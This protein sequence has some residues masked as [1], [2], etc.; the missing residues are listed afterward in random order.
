MRYFKA[1]AV[2]AVAAVGFHAA[3]AQAA[4]EHR[5]ICVF[6]IIG[7]NGDSFN[8]MRDYK[9][10]AL[11]WGVDITLKPYT[12]E[13]IAAEDLKAGQCDGAILTGL[14]IRQFNSY[15]GSME[16]IG[17]IPNYKQ[18]HTVMRVLMSNNPTINKH[19]KTEHYTIGGLYPMG[20]AYLFVKDKSIDTVDELSGKSIA[21]MDYLSLIHI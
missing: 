6:D 12:N 16:A 17:A 8:L 10:A 5:T 11:G 7:S 4:L 9:V 13:K 15:S 14:R 21:V 19:L 3:P 18:L 2:A 20:A 1:L